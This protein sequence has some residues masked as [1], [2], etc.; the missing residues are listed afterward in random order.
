MILLILTS[1]EILQTKILSTAFLVVVE[2]TVPAKT[3]SAGPAYNVQGR[4]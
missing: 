3:D 2:L 1:F 4:F